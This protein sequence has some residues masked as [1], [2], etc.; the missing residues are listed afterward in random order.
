[1]IDK[2]L[3]DHLKEFKFGEPP[4]MLNLLDRTAI[5]LVKGNT[6]KKRFIEDVIM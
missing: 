3:P 2:K 1:M 5:D 4:S 6:A